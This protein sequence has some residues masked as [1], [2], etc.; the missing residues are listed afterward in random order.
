MLSTADLNQFKQISPLLQL[1]PKEANPQL[2]QMMMRLGPGEV[3]EQLLQLLHQRAVDLTEFYQA[4]LRTGS[5]SHVIDAIRYLQAS[6]SPKTINLLRKL[7]EHENPAIRLEAIRALI[8]Q[9]EQYGVRLIPQLISSLTMPNLDLRNLALKI[10]EQLKAPEQVSQLLQFTRKEGFAHWK[11]EQRQRLY[12]A[13]INWGGP[14]SNDFVIRTVTTSNAM[15]R[16]ALEQN[17]ME[18]LQALREQGDERSWRLL[19]EC[20]ETRAPKAIQL[21]IHEVIDEIEQR[22]N[23]KSKTKQ[24]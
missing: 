1:M 16:K 12:K 23:T 6:S 4:R 15:R 14:L 2:L 10:L 8:D 20:R 19:M 18:M 11:E 9:D 24:D 7:S 5:E 13:I 3:Q 17:R 22:L 21:F